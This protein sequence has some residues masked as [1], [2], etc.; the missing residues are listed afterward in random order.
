MTLNSRGQIYLNGM[1]YEKFGKPRAVALYYSREDDSIALEPSF[2]R[3]DESF[4]LVKKQ[5]GWVI[6][7]SSFCRH[8]RIRVPTT[9]RFLRPGIGNEGHLF[10]SLRETISVGG[11][12]SNAR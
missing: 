5:N 8:H 7:A 4:P 3:S 9:E 1:A 6:H 2:E 12:G 11:T 10:L